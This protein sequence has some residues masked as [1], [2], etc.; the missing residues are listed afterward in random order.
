MVGILLSFENELAC[1]PVP[2]DW[3]FQTDAH[4]LWVD[5]CPERGTRTAGCRRG[6]RNTGS[7]DRIAPAPGDA[8][9]RITHRLRSGYRPASGE[10]RYSAASRCPTYLRR[11]SCR[12]RPSHSTGSAHSQGTP[13][14][15][16][17]T[18]VE[19]LLEPCD[20][21]EIIRDEA[22]P[23]GWLPGRSRGDGDHII[24]FEPSLAAK[25][26]QRLAPQ[27]VGLGR[28]PYSRRNAW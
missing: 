25:I 15:G 27:I 6:S 9:L 22:R 26:G 7:A 28:E 1:D 21:R 12:A 16:V 18:I 11:Q 3:L 24:R 17:K 10:Y 19:D 13:P 14:I 5:V 2:D 20:K 8:T 23:E 4:I